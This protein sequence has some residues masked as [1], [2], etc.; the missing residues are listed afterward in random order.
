MDGV[1]T[2]LILK[3]HPTVLDKYMVLYVDIL[4]FVSTNV[5]LT[6]L[7]VCVGF[8]FRWTWIP[9]SSRSAGY[10]HESARAYARQCPRWAW[11]PHGRTHAGPRPNATWTSRY[12]SSTSDVILVCR[13]VIR[14]WVDLA[15]AC[16]QSQPAVA[17]LDFLHQ[18][19]FRL[20]LN[21]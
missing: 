16:K 7:Y 17:H 20:W 6:V 5:M 1:A 14:L 13:S 4:T 9:Q 12:D 18:L 8:L 3:P 10:A 21:R 11:R 19:P 15:E 2:S